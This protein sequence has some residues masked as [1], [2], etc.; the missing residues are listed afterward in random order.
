MHKFNRLLAVLACVSLLPGRQLDR[1]CGTYHNNWR[2]ELHLHR[3]S[4]PKAK[5]RAGSKQAIKLLPDLGNIAHLEATDGVVAQRNPYNLSGKTIRFVLQTGNRPTYR[6]TTTEG[7]YDAGA[8]ASGSVIDGLGDDDSR[9]VGLPFDFPFFGTA[10]RT[11]FVNSDG[12]LTFGKG[13]SDITD[14]SLGRMLSGPPRIAP[15]FNDLD[16]TRATTGVRVRNEPNR[17]VISWDAVPEYRDSGRGPQQTFQVR[18]FRDGA[19]ELAYASGTPTEAVAGI[20]PGGLKGDPALVAFTTTPSTDYTSSIV[21]RFS[22]AE[23]IDIFAAAQKFY[24][25][26]DDAYDYLVIYNTM[27]VGAGP[28]SV[29][30][31]VTVRNNRTGYGDV[32]AEVGEQ[33]G[34]KK[35]LQAILNMGPLNQYPTDPNGP[36]PARLTSGDTPLT[37]LAHETGHLFL[38]YA[39]VPDE[40][41]GTPML[42]HQLAHWNFTF[43][44]DASLM[45]GNRIEDKGVGASPRFLTTGTVEGYSALDQYLMGLLPPEQVPDTFYVKDPRG[46]STT[47]VPKKGVA[48]DGTRVNVSI[49]DIIQ[50]VDRRTPDHTVAQ[51]QFRFAFLIVT[52]DGATPTAAQLAQVEAYRTQFEPFFARATAQNATAD[53]TLRKSIAV[54]GFP[55]FGV[56]TNGKAP[57][58][59]SL[60]Q[61]AAASMTLQVRSKS[62]RLGVPSTVTIPAGATQATFEVTGL[63]QGTD[64]LTVE[65]SS[66]QFDAITSKVQVTQTANV[67]LRIES[68][69]SPIKV[70]VTDANNL[71]YPGVIVQASA[72]AGGSLDRASAPTAANGI[73]EFRWTQ[74]TQGANSVQ[75]SVAGGPSETIRAAAAPSF[76][77]TGIVNAASYVAGLVPGSI[78]TVFGANLGGDNAQVIL[79]GR[80]AQ[81]FFANSTQINFVT[82]G[83][84]PEGTADLIV[85]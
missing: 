35:R 73:A 12:N 13:D 18:L 80:S 33:A 36:V 45:E 29:A 85:R 1:S 5:L 54:S 40:D 69:S 14:R 59:V 84:L 16:P 60:E 31:E 56:V 51:R 30:T 50:A 8:A 9:E 62:G 43:N 49:Q 41:G 25:N 77:A 81:V 6:F 28:T 75:V 32:P 22:D 10:Y 27:N 55:A 26:H 3:S 20:T 46:A 78:A 68:D 7:T 83:G 38:A 2:E 74:S 67:R 4:A 79:N 82:P 11:V 61:P 37:V 42:G 57:V 19:I 34:S 17:V 71:P 58:T 52:P 64:D 15:Q 70:Q 47:G 23:S 66:N 72:S 21:E 53:T 39:T 24:R 44:S 76:A 65:P 63:S 48:F